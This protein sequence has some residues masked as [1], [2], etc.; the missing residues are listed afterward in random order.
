MADAD[1]VEKNNDTEN[2]EA[3]YSYDAAR[4]VSKTAQLKDITIYPDRRLPAFDKG[5][6]KAYIAKAKNGNECYALLCEKEFVPRINSISKIENVAN[7]DLQKPLSYGTFYWPADDSFRL[8]FVFER[9][10]GKPFLKEGDELALGLKQEVV[11][12]AVI[13]PMVNIMLDMWDSEL[14]HG[15]INPYNM[16]K[17][18]SAKLEGVILG[19]CLTLPFSY[20]QPA[21]F[22]TIPRAMTDPIARGYS[23]FEDDLYAFG[24]TLTVLM[25]SHD[26]LKE[27]TDREI[28]KNKLEFGSYTTLVGKDHFTGAILELLRGLL[29]D[30]KRQRWGIE[31]VLT[32]MDGRRLSPKQSNVVIKRA[33]RPLKFLKK[34]YLRPDLLVLDLQDDVEESARLIESDELNQWIVRSVD[35]KDKGRALQEAIE[36]ARETGKDSNYTDKVVSRAAMAMS[37]LLPIQYKKRV[38]LPEGIG[39]AMAQSFVRREN[40]APY[41]ELFAQGTVV[42]WL[43]LNADDIP[44]ATALLSRY[45]DCH[46]FLKDSSRGQGPERC[47]YLLSPEAPCMSE[48]LD[49]YYIRGPE[50]LLKAYEDMAQKDE[51]SPVFFDRHI[52]AF[53]SVRD[54]KVIDPHMVDLN[55]KDKH[56]NLLAILK[57]L[58]GL[59]RRSGKGKFPALSD[60]VVDVVRPLADHF[61]DDKLKEKIKKKLTK[62]R[63]SGDL[64]KILHLLDD[65]SAIEDDNT[66]F[67]YAMYEYQSLRSEAIKLQMRLDDRDVF[68]KGTGQEI[69]AI[70]SGLIASIIIF[71]FT[72][73]YFAQNKGF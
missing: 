70:V 29:Q 47:L 28:I 41:V 49:K 34:N 3:D 51:R 73:I 64:T 66:A 5:P 33:A 56:R 9:N 57:I 71:A 44:N 31:E 23:A 4:Y 19:D 54:P 16:Y 72:L 14:V 15:S 6:L 62:Y 43:K 53:L 67:K 39:A 24:V 8:G 68:G 32:W 55:S 20:A 46:N 30:D 17:K 2:M 42:Y 22:E 60:W 35:D 50:S 25:R 63:K 7:P 48:M 65:R 45:N 52:I 58:A 1:N 18:E 36:K 40:L 37:P 13:K 61:H 27:M 26:H 21:L 12:N 59:Q 38:Y 10:I 69:S 11:M